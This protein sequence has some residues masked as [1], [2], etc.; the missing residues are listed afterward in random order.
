MFVARG[1]DR[2]MAGKLPKAPLTEVVFEMRW[3]IPPTASTSVPVDPAYS[4]VFDAVSAFA[5]KHGFGRVVD[6]HKPYSGIPPSV[7]RRM[8]RGEAPFPLLQV[9]PSI[10]AYNE[11]VD[12]EWTSF[13]KAAVDGALAVASSL[14]NYREFKPEISRLE[15][16]YIDAFDPSVVGAETPLEF[17][18]KGTN[19]TL[20]PP[21]PLSK[22]LRAANGARVRLEWPV[23]G[24][25]ATLFSLELASAFR[26]K[27]PIMRMESKVVWTGKRFPAGSK[28]TRPALTSWLES[29]H[30]VTSASFKAIVSQQ[31]FKTFQGAD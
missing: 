4:K 11:S 6:L 5:A 24:A 18:E 16:R 22:Q 13:R 17:L 2:T 21:P 15:L 8:Y 23:V 29:A 19:M 3:E 9:G 14:S 25:D 26:E 12:Y 27:K 28:P 7:S 30:K 31:M 10:F 20:S 1:S